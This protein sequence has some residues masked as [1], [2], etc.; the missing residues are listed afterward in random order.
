MTTLEET[1]AGF[2]MWAPGDVDRPLAEL[3]AEGKVGSGYHEGKSAPAE[4]KV[5]RGADMIVLHFLKA[6]ISLK[7]VVIITAVVAPMLVMLFLTASDIATGLIVPAIAALIIAVVLFMSLGKL[8]ARRQLIL[9]RDRVIVAALSGKEG[10]PKVSAE[11]ILDEIEGVRVARGTYGGRTLWF[12]TDRG[13]FPAGDNA[14]RPAH[15]LVIATLAT[16]KDGS[17]GDAAE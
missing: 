2:D 11:L 9:R 7:L 17:Q 15:D 8:R 5:E 16:A 1:A 13:S 10:E 3:A 14:P 4:L 12:D 6:P